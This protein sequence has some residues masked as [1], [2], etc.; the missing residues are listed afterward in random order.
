MPPDI[1]QLLL[2]L[3]S[4]SKPCSGGSLARRL[5]GLKIRPDDPQTYAEV[6]AA[7]VAL[8]AAGK[9]TRASNGRSAHYRLAKP[10]P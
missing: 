10:T 4:D 9:V 2:N 3:L 8:V 7:L 1:E 6:K 5:M